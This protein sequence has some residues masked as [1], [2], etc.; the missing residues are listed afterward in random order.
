MSV[1]S[2]IRKSLGWSCSALGPAFGTHAPSRQNGA[3]LGKTS[4]TVISCPS[5]F[6]LQLSPPC[7]TIP[8]SPSTRFVLPFLQAFCTPVCIRCIVRDYE[9]SGAV[10]LYHIPEA[11]KGLAH[12]RFRLPPRGPAATTMCECTMGIHSSGT[13]S[14]STPFT[15]TTVASSRIQAAT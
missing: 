1:R 2:A 9:S 8:Y 11:P 10:A 12:Q 14:S 15:S 13:A 4:G 5:L 6:A 3:K 7:G